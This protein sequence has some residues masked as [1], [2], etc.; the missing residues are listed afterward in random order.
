[1]R[2][3][4]NNERYFPDT[5]HTIQGSKII[6]RY[7]EK[8]LNC[9]KISIVLY[10]SKCWTV[11][12]EMMKRFEATEVGLLM[13]VGNIIQGLKNRNYKEIATN[14]QKATTD[15]LGTHNEDKMLEEFSIHRHI[16]G[17]RSKRKVCNLFNK[18][19]NG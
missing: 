16:E 6:L 19:V 18:Q 5:K 3:N 13:N 1:M 17:K 10:D 4:R 8:R 14:N 7:K 15:I 9:Y 11:L 2:L 12:S